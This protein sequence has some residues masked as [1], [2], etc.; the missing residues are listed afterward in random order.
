MK[1]WM[2]AN[3]VVEFVRADGYYWKSGHWQQSREQRPSTVARVLLAQGMP[4]SEVEA[5]QIE[6]GVWY[7]PGGPV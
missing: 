1:F 2:R 4:E 5:L 7:M 3:G 6:P